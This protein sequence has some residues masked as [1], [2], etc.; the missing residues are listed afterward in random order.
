MG[1]FQLAA[2][3]L[4]IAALTIGLAL[5]CAGQHETI[6]TVG[7]TTIPRTALEHWTAV[8]H[9]TGEQASQRAVLGNLIH[10][11]WD[12]AEAAQLGVRVTD[13]EVRKQLELLQFAQAQ[14][15]LLRLLPGEGALQRLLASPA[16]TTDDRLWLVKMHL[17]SL[18]VQQ[19]LIA[20]AE[21]QL[22]RHLIA[23]FY[24]H[25]KPRYTEAE[26][27]DIEIFMTRDLA[28]AQQGKREV[29]AGKS[30]RS[31][32]RRL[33]VSREADHGLVMG[34]ARGAGEPPFERHVFHAKPGVIIGP[35][36]QA[37]FYVFR[38][39]KIIP[40]RLQ[41]LARAEASIKH[42]LAVKQAS[43]T[44]RPALD[45]RWASRT[46]CRPGYAIAGCRP[47]AAS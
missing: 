38:V 27:R 29:L 18:R 39:T 25:N 23:S 47:A 30:F 19:R 12:S 4:A 46:S 10:L 2:V 41:P 6:A 21:R 14:R 15:E 36:E 3:W 1:R 13:A 35:V 34:L 9:A 42:Q 11:S 33:N 24:R 28:H 45:R 26:R 22:S 44:L 37:L 32:A 43:S 16:A 7:E 8:Q 5:G 20:H 40:P 31:V 17:L